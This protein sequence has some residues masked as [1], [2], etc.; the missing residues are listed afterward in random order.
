MAGAPAG[1]RRLPSGLTGNR[2][3]MASHTESIERE[4]KFDTDLAFALPD[5]RGI[6]GRTVRLP[7]LT[8]R[9]AYVDTV[10]FRLWRRGI[11]LRH[12]TGEGPEEGLWTLKLPAAG[13]GATLDRSELNWVGDR[14]AFPP[15]A[16]RVLRGLL[17]TSEL[18]QIVEL[19]TTRVRLALVDSD[20][21]HLGEVDDDSVTVIGGQRDGFRF[22]QIEVELDDAGDAVIDA[23]VTEFKRAGV[24]PGR[25]PKLSKALELPRRS[26][27]GPD[28]RLR[29]RSSLGEVVTA[30]LANA[31]GR[32]LDHDYRL[33][34]RSPQV[35]PHDVHQVRVA[36][37]RLRSD[38]KTLGTALDPIWLR[39]TRAELKWLGEALGGVRDCDVLTTRLAIGPSGSRGDPSE[40]GLADA[41][42][43]QR[44]R[45]VSHLAQVVESDRYLALLDRLEAGVQRPPFLAGTTTGGSASR[46]PSPT[47]RATGVLPSMVGGQWRRLRRRVRRAGAHPTDHQLHRIRIDAKQLRYAAELSEPIIG[48]PARRT[49]RAAEQLQSILG[50]HHDAVV[51]EAWCRQVGLAPHSVA[52][53]AAGR[54]S[55]GQARLQRKLR[56]RW[57]SVANKLRS[58]KRTSWL[59]RAGR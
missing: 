1:P 39:H 43:D 22:R 29:R 31:L 9:A 18:T 24:R 37:R 10:D 38:L 53:F 27:G 58:N 3:L 42:A 28:G 12:R 6:V 33:R 59:D 50:E 7:E 14:Q 48:K 55:E 44:R 34:L 25:Q 45:A 23:V 57:Q 52:G 26:P 20:G 13:R 30:S 17:R 8:L 5:L 4:A 54:R 46:Y 32:I 36:T 51:A 16:A 41:L 21:V 49:A 2:K 19:A 11:T 40:Q 15:E 47:D 35:D 56:G